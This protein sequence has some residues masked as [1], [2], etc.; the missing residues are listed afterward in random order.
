MFTLTSL[1]GHLSLPHSLKALDKA[2]AIAEAK[3]RG[4][5]LPFVV[6]NDRNEVVFETAGLPAGLCLTYPN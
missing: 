3:A 5:R 6:R 2:G 4:C 1:Q